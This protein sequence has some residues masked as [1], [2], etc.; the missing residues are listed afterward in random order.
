MEIINKP[1]RLNIKWVSGPE[2]QPS[3]LRFQEPCYFILRAYFIGYSRHAET[4][5]KVATAREELIIESKMEAQDHTTDLFIHRQ[6]ITY[7]LQINTNLE[8]TINSS[9]DFDETFTWHIAIIYGCPSLPPSNISFYIRSSE[10]EM[11]WEEW[12]TGLPSISSAAPLTSELHVLD[13]V[14]H[15][16]YVHSQY[17]SGATTD[18]AHYQQMRTEA[19]VPYLI[20]QRTLALEAQMNLVQT[21]DQDQAAIGDILTSRTRITNTGTVGANFV[22][23]RTTLPRCAQLLDG[24]FTINGIVIAIG[25]DNQNVI[26][27]ILRNMPVHDLLDVSIQM[28]FHSDS[29]DAPIYLDAVIDYHFLAVDDKWLVGNQAS[30]LVELPPIPPIG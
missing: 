29:A 8:F 6:D 17:F 14:K 30:N 20:A 19:P 2:E 13:G 11:L 9:Q 3:I 5:L 25:T 18:Q 21:V 12:Q 23:Y 4:T 27:V 24:G 15:Q 10:G 16:E 22:Q 7:F 26:T 28:L 1:D